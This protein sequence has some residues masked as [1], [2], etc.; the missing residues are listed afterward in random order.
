MARFIPDTSPEDVPHDS[1]RVVM[2]AL[3]DLPAGYVVM[4][5]FPW[6]RPTRDLA[7][8]PLHE[9]EADFVILHPER[10]MLVLEVKG[11]VPELRG[12]TWTR[13][14]REMR[15]PFEQARRNRYALLDAIEERTNGSVSRAQFTHGDAVVF[16]HCQYD[17]PLPINADD[18]ILL[19]AR[20]LSELPARI[21]A[22]FAAWQRRPTRLS[23]GEF[24]ALLDA[25][26]PKLR[27]LRCVGTEVAAEGQRIIQVTRDQRATLQGL[28]ANDRVLIEGTAGAGK[29]LLAYEFA[30]ALAARGQAVLLLCYNKH[31]AAWLD[32]QTRADPRIAGHGT[33]EV[34][35]FHAFAVALARRSEVEFE[36]PARGGPEFW[37]DE[38]PLI[39]EQALEILR[40]RSAA[41]LF[42]AVIVDEA[43]D[44]ARD[45]W[46]TV[47]GL[48]RGGRHGRLYAFLDLHQSL[49]RDPQLPPVPLHARF[50]LTANCR[51][52]RTIAR[53]ASC[54]TGAEVTLLPGIPEGEAPSTRRAVT[55]AA[56]AGLVLEEIRRRTKQGIKPH[57]I[58]VIGPAAHNKG[59]L[60][61]FDE[62]DG[63]PFTTDAA[64][65]RRGG[66]ILV[67]TARAFKG[68]ESDF[69]LLYDLSGFGALFTPTDLYVAWTRARHRLIAVCHGAEV[70]GAIEKALAGAE[71][72]ATPDD[73]T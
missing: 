20:S 23:A 7:R 66:G 55:A 44:F 28:L 48:T 33:V 70:R 31:L 54:I 2:R 67:T 61:R 60:A 72:L 3:R 6:L 12:R 36:V 50:R 41:P 22:A 14:A 64:D 18:R 53:S 71:R 34:S 11:G 65:W 57:Q 27:L 63:V 49:R 73:L 37:D 51:N 16:P 13:G 35:T 4:H 38:V 29:T 32:E 8:G 52:T 30:A 10:G 15:D 24:S 59:A 58:A 62:V 9:G 21:E 26:M 46:V 19:D 47:E 68:L 39:L 40:S 17:G 25:L 1:E 69:V 43:Q 45:W 56:Q 42:D 5:S